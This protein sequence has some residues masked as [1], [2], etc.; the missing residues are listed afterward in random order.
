MTEAADRY[1]C[2]D[3]VRVLEDSPGGNP[4][5]PRYVRGREGVVTERHGVIPNP[6]DHHGLYPPLYSVTFR[7]PD[8]GGAEGADLVVVDLHE[9][10]LVPA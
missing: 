4:R 7:L 3:R 2:G 9:E 5:T 10:W 1:R 6:L 8:L